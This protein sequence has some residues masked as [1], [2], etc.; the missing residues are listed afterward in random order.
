MLALIGS[1]APFDRARRQIQ[2]LA[3]LEVTAK[4]VERTAEAAGE[5][6]SAGEREEIQRAVQPDLPVMVGEPIPIL[7][8]R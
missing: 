8:I 1:E 4:A 3:G 7:Y 5:D 2:L 6:I